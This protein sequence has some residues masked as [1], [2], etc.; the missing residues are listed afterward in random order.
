MNVYIGVHIFIY[1]SYI[2]IRNG[3]TWSRAME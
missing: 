2:Y 1:I 3:S